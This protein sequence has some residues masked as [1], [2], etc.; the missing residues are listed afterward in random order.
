MG[1]RTA[2]FHGVEIPE[3]LLAAEMLN[4]RA[5][6]MSDARAMAGRALAA[7]AVLLARAQALGLKAVPERNAEGMEETGAEALVRLALSKDVAVDPPCEEA[8]RAIYDAQ[9]EGFKTPP[10][11][12]A[13]HILIAPSKAGA[14]ALDEARAQALAL[15]QMLQGTPER[16]ERLAAM[17]SACPS[18]TAGGSL[19]QL[20][21]GDVLQNIWA[22]L[23]ALEVG[24]IG[25]SP[26]LT[27]HGWH[28]LRLDHRVDGARL[29]FDHVRPHIAAQM[30]ARAWTLAAALHVDKLLKAHAASPR[31]R[32]TEEGDLSTGE[33]N[34]VRAN[35]L[36]GAALANPVQALA[37]IH[38]DGL[39]TLEMA[40]ARAGQTA[41]E[42]LGTA[43]NHFL[44]AAD[45][46]A[47]TQVISRLQGSGA[48]LADCLD[49]I[50]KHQLQQVTV[51]R[52][53]KPSRD[54]GR[55]AAG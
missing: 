42:A 20:R 5:A 54:K 27:Q 38:G 50:I 46:A 6:S 40:A 21:P 1:S 4:H 16:F 19:G 39:K 24:E 44:R 13:S 31:L 12:E 35:G 45:D 33:N 8:V 43:V 25:V 23:L 15:A 47:W 55:P 36:I 2:I 14:A 3:T 28:I 7:K 51:R 30:E 17:H 10:L 18:A 26:L 22:A 11:L 52:K 29:P 48:P 9:P 41:A 53:I 49:V 32:L 37:H 34:V